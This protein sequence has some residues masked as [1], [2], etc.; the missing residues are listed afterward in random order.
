MIGKDAAIEIAREYSADRGWSFDEPILFD[1]GRP[2][3]RFGREP[4]V[5]KL[6]TNGTNLGTKAWF[7][8][9]RV[10]G[11]VIAAGYIPH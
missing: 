10:S 8:I 7:E 5:F 2:L 11:K 1:E 6:W 3:F 9:D 4:R